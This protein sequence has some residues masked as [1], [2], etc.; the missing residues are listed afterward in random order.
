MI[1]RRHHRNIYPEGSH[2]RRDRDVL[3]GHGAAISAEVGIGHMAIVLSLQWPG[4][5]TSQIR[6]ADV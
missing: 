3:R 6:T 4:G 2:E 1:A 5:R